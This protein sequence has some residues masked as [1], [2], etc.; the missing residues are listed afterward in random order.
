[1]RTLFAL[2]LMAL[3]IVPATAFAGSP[4]PECG[5]TTPSGPWKDTCKE[6]EWQKLSSGWSWVAWCIERTYPND[7]Y[8]LAGIK[9]GKVT[10]CG[11]ELKNERGYFRCK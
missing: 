6:G 11:F 9:C 7:R 2:A 5:K 4:K 3:L 1:M 10:Q 8:R